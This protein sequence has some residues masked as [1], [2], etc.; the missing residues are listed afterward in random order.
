MPNYVPG[1]G[2]PAAK[3]VVIGE[4]P[5]ADED[6]AGRPF[7]GPAGHIL[8]EVLSYA[9]ISRDECYITNVV[10]VRP[11]QN[12]LSKLHILGC[13]IE[14]FLPQLEEEIKGINPNVIF[15]LGN[16]PL[17][18]VAGQT[19]ITNYRGSILLTKL[20]YKYIPSIHPAAVLH[21]E[22]AKYRDLFLIKQDAV[23]VKQQSAFPEIN[24]PSRNII[25][26]K[27]STQLEA[28]L[29]RNET[30]PSNEII[31]RSKFP[32]KRRIVVDIET[33]RRYP[34][35]IGL[36]LNP[37]ESISI[38]MYSEEIPETDLAYIWEIIAELFMSPDVQ[39][40]GQNAKFDSKRCRWA[41]LKW[42][43]IWFDIMQA[44]HTLFPELPKDLA[45]ISSILTEE[46]YYKSE[47]KEYNPKKDPI[48]KWMT[49]NG[50]DAY[51]EW[52]CYERLHEM[53]IEEDLEEFFFTRVAPLNALYDRI[54]DIG[55]K[56]DEER[57]NQMR[58]AF[59]IK[60]REKEKQ[61]HELLKILLGEDCPVFNYNAHAKIGELL[62]HH[63]KIPFRKDVGEKTLKAL[64]NNT[65]K[66]PMKK[67]VII[68]ILECRKISK[69]IGTYL[70]FKLKNAGEI[71]GG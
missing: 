50:K 58:D 12:D 59:T 34:L 64:V 33:F 14:Q 49:Y 55:I 8:D 32:L 24:R 22:T 11:P 53:L 25:L 10:K 28:L 2:N 36:A 67:K 70:N 37:W 52:E 4:A 51:T 16:T 3:I 20:G 35:L 44:W 5:G 65:V 60:L 27:S 15:G 46:P 31:A 19:G 71:L 6:L 66:D 57:R 21:G 29:S 18:Y 26:C 48:E 30:N 47:G 45:T 39:L 69:T 17:Q 62:Y 23:R 41:G 38:S 54:E 9:G 42:R 1:Y 63:L 40:I 61:L 7:V 68:L 43:E 56:I 13:S